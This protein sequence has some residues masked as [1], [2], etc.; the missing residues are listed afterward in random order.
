L[1]CAAVALTAINDLDDYLDER[2]SEYED[3]GKYRSAA[4]WLI[5]V[6]I[7]GMF[8]EGAIALLRILNVTLVNQN[9]VIF[10]I[11]V[12]VFMIAKQYFNCNYIII[13]IYIAI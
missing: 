13:L 4:G 1:I 9:F 2:S 10:G 11:I 7:M 3:A 5:F 6:A 8:I 12:S